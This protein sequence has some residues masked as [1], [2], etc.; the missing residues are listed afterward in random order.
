MLHLS[1]GSQALAEHILRVLHER[2]EEEPF[3]S[4]EGHDSSIPSAVML[5]IGQRGRHK[6]REPCL[7]L[8][9]RSQKVRQPGDIC[10]PGGSLSPRADRCFAKLLTLPGLPMARWPYWT[11]WHERHPRKAGQLALLLGT[12]LRESFEEM[13]LNP[14]GVRF[15]GPLPPQPLQMF[16]RVIYPMAGWVPRQERFFP[17][18]EVEKVV[19]IPLRYLLNADFYARY[20]LQFAPSLKEK[21]HRQAE[22]F[23]CFLY[24]HQDGQELLWGATYR[25]ITAFLKLVFGFI[26]PDMP[27]RPAVIHGTLEGDYLTGANDPD[28][29][30]PGF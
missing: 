13:R 20:R 10:C 8:N 7:I 28:A 19:W 17:N 5:L 6:G 21:F 29:T 22:D 9:K 11:L 25:I 26:P 30:K 18:W 4:T 1:N 27:S 2:H 23:P 16:R 14:F 3:F 24:P 12:G 15:L